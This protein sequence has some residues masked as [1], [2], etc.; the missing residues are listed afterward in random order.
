MAYY[1]VTV[2]LKDG[3]ECT[4]G[5]LATDEEQ[6]AEFVM[7]ELVERQQRPVEVVN[8]SA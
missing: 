5:V 8:A 3:D 4:I 2:L 7:E 6:A 1:E